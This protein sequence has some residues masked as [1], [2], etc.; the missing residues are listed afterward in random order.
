MFMPIATQ[1]PAPQVFIGVEYI[2]YS[3]AS[4]ALMAL[5]CKRFFERTSWPWAL[6]M[7]G[8]FGLIHVALFGAMVGLVHG[9]VDDMTYYALASPIK[10]LQFFYVFLPLCLGAH[11]AIK[12]AA[13]QEVENVSIFD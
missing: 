11:A 6:G 13:G 5:I 1:V 8:L 9:G 2:G 12:W 10:A 3:L 4:G 7:S